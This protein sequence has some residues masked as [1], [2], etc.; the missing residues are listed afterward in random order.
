M[1]IFVLRIVIIMLQLGLR[2]SFRSV[3]RSRGIHVPDSCYPQAQLRKRSFSF[4][5]STSDSSDGL[6]TADVEIDPGIALLAKSKAAEPEKG[7]LSIEFLGT[8][9]CIPTRTRGVSCVS[10]TY[11]GE[12]WLFDCG[13]NTQQK[14]MR[15]AVRPT[16]IKKIFLTHLH[17]DHV[18]GLPGLLCFVGQ[19]MRSQSDLVDTLDIYGPEGTRSFVRAAL[20]LTESTVAPPLRIHEL[21]NVPV[22]RGG[23][24]V[25][26]KTKPVATRPDHKEK[27]GR[28]IYPDKNMEYAVISPSSDVKAGRSVKR[29]SSNL[30]A[31][32]SAAA[33]SNAEYEGEDTR[34]YVYA[35][36]MDH[37][38]PCVGYVVHE[39]DTK[40]TLFPEKI[41]PLIERNK[42]ALEIMLAARKMKADYRKVL[43]L[44]KVCGNQC[45]VAAFCGD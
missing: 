40:P 35:A 32:G 44:L 29:F 11:C 34:L 42:D 1:P 45:L 41:M 30:S 10:L 13:E 39:L 22:F 43:G 14:L 25:E 4:L 33:S 5:R 36:P 15:S 23:H 21:K 20:Q 12:T 3:V 27:I 2:S 17:G 38:I 31:A 24:A 19:A 9:S 18:F 7:D 26:W 37:S 6:D 16:S 8:S 28:D